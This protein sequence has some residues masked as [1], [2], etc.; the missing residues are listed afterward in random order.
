MVADPGN[1]SGWGSAVIA[2]AFTLAVL[3]LGGFAVPGRHVPARNHSALSSLISGMVP[4]RDASSVLCGE[5][6]PPRRGRDGRLSAILTAE[7]I[8]R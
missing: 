7:H 6:S 8:K 4:A 2:S 3:A 1:T 5:R